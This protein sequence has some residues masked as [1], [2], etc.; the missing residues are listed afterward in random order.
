MKRTDVSDDDFSIVY[1]VSRGAACSFDLTPPPILVT[2]L[3]RPFGP[4]RCFV[5]GEHVYWTKNHDNAKFQAAICD[6]DIDVLQKTKH[7]PFLRYPEPTGNNNEDVLEKKSSG[8]AEPNIVVYTNF[9]AAGLRST[10]S[11]SCNNAQL[12]PATVGQKPW[13]GL[14]DGHYG[15]VVRTYGTVS[16][17]RGGLTGV[18]VSADHAVRVV[19][20]ERWWLLRGPRLDATASTLPRAVVCCI[21]VATF[22]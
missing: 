5:V 21:N 6:Y 22:A 4:D 20:A 16:V 9:D 18:D 14:E 13:E 17:N 15:P 12:V 2:A 1:V 19:V 8:T 7:A 3:P 10:N 11:K